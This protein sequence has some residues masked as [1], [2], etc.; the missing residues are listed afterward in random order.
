MVWYTTHA[1]PLGEHTVGGYR[2]LQY[3]IEGMEDAEGDVS[4]QG[5]SWEWDGEGKF[6]DCC[7]SQ[8]LNLKVWNDP[9]TWDEIVGS[10]EG[11]D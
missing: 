7:G 8:I 11:R 1:Q 9:M 4:A 10:Y 3:M 2:D 5:D 6:R